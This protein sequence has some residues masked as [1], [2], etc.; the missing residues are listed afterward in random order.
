MQRSTVRAVVLA[1]GAGWRFGGGKVLAALEDR[2]L[3]Q[4]VLDALAEAGIDDPF[5][6]LGRDAGAVRAALRW[7][8]ATIVTNPEPELGLASSLQV[9]WRSA[10]D[11]GAAAVLVAL[12]DQPRL[13]PAVVTALLE[14]ELDP[15]HP[16]VAPRYVG[17]GGRN[18]VRIEATGDALVRGLLG[19]R[20]L[21]PL[22]AA[23]PDLVRSIDV[24]GSNPDVDRPE[25]LRAIARP[26]DPA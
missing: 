7:R 11:A 18:P 5:V 19:D 22:I 20:G 15:A 21:G 16:I 25:D 4:H 24:P 17:G 14:P 10:L 12:A 6:V 3:L 13:S 9:G 26:G 23:R 2:P 8:R 1:A